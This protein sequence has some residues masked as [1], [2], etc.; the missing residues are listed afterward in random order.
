MAKVQVNENLCKGCELCV[1]V[2]PRQ[3][4]ALAK[5][6]LNAKGYHP[7]EVV[8]PDD[9][10]GCAMCYMTCPDVAIRVEK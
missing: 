4:L 9:C 1:Q 8:K 10:I 7:C 3:V 2:C 5:E 6:R